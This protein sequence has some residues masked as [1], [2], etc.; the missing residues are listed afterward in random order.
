MAGIVF[1]I[2]GLIQ[3]ALTSTLQAGVGKLDI[4][5]SLLLVRYTVGKCYC[6]YDILCHWFPDFCH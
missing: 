1:M 4:L 3:T 5:F 6:T 2:I